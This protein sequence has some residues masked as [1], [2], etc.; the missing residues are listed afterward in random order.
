MPIVT[1]ADV[2]RVVR[3]D[4]GP[5]HAD[6]VLALLLTYGAESWQRE[7]PRVRLAILRLAGGDIEHLRRELD[8]AKRDYRD[9]LLGAEYLSYGALTLR[10]P[11]PSPDDAQRAIAADWGAYQEWL[12]R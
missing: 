9:V 5:A 10:T 6:D 4:Y 1:D 7:A 8:V 3:R 12:R 2:E 11:H